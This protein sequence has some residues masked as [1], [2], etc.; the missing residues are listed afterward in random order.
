[1]GRKLIEAP[2]LRL[3]II[4]GQED[5]FLYTIGW[6]QS[7]QRGEVRGYEQGEASFDNRIYCCGPTSASTWCS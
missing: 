2:L 3:Q 1:V 4:G 7:I 5:P 6:D